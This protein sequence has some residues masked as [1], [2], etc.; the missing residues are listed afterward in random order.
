MAAPPPSLSPLRKARTV[1]ARH[2]RFPQR[3]L[4]GRV[5]RLEGWKTIVLH[6]KF[7]LAPQTS[8]RPQRRR[9]AVSKY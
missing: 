3:W 9:A 1:A 6:F 7:S 4:K 2:L 8:P 5:T